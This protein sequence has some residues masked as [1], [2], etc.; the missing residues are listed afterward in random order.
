MSGDTV[1]NASKE[2]SCGGS[3][4]HAL[5]GRGLSCARILISLGTSACPFLGA[6]PWIYKPELE[7]V[8]HQCGWRSPNLAFIFQAESYYLIPDH[9]I[10]GHCKV[11]RGQ[12]MC[13]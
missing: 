4:A 11:F 5:N 7:F 9:G 12:V 2:L 13:M 1:E 3:S 10:L 6:V 8:S